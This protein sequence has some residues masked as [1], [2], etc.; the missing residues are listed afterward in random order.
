MFEMERRRRRRRRRRKRW[1]RTNKRTERANKKSV[2]INLQINI[3]H[4][5][6]RD[7]KRF[8][9]PVPPHR[10]I[11][12]PHTLLY[13]KMRW[14]TGLTSGSRISSVQQKK[15]RQ[16]MGPKKNPCNLKCKPPEIPKRTH[17][18][19]TLAQAQYVRTY[20]QTFKYIWVAL[21]LLEK[22]DWPMM[23]EKDTYALHC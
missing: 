15:S 21:M 22:K 23:T 18:H 16:E 12:P 9:T 11:A 1:R 5:I 19:S 13:N 17:T 20:V 6:V 7:S 4:W 10:T 2:Y 8:P 3:F 14:H